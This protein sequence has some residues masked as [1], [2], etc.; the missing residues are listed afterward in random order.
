MVAWSVARS[1]NATT[2]FQKPLSFDTVFINV[3]NRWNRELNKVLINTGGTYF[4]HIDLSTCSAGGS[5]M[6]LWKNNEV[7]FRARSPLAA[8]NAP[9]Q[10][11]GHAA[12]LK[13]NTDDQL[14]A[15][16]A[17]IPPAC[18]LGGPYFHTAFYGFLLSLE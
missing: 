13:L 8:N 16:V 5:E 10:V 14:Y 7:A 12:V 1:S 4:A 17:D 11:R 9:G 3:G 6:E 2:G 18:I 15:A